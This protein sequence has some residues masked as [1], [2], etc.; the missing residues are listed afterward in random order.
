M[1]KI[2]KYAIEVDGVIQALIQEV[3]KPKNEI[4]AV[5]HGV[6]NHDEK[7]AGGVTVNDATIRKVKPEANGDSWAWDWL[8]EAQD[9]NTNQGGLES[10]YKRDL[11]FRELDPKGRTINSWL[12]EGVWVRAVDEGDYKQGNKSENVLEEVTLSVD[13]VKRIR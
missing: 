10:D 12:W 13:R 8:M 4:G 6:G 9:P 2:F 3:K 7:T 5:T 11:V 1:R